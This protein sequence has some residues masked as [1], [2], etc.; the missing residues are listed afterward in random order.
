MKTLIAIIF[1][2]INFC[3]YTF[4]NLIQIN[5]VTIPLDLY[6]EIQ[7][8]NKKTGYSHD[9]GSYDETNSTYYELITKLKTRVK[10]DK[11]FLCPVC[12]VEYP[13]SKYSTNYFSIDDSKTLD[14][15]LCI[16]DLPYK[17]SYKLPT[18]CIFCGGIFS[19]PDYDP[20][21]SSCFW[22][23]WRC[24]YQALREEHDTWK[25]FAQTAYLHDLE[26]EYGIA[27]I[28]LKASRT[29]ENNNSKRQN[30]LN[31]AIEHLNKY[32]DICQRKNLEYYNDYLKNG[33]L[34]KKADFLRQ[35]GNFS[36]AASITVF[37]RNEID[38]KYS[39][40][41]IVLNFIDDLIA[42]KD[43]MPAILPFGNRLHWAIH[44]NQTIGSDTL[45][46]ITD[47]FKWQNNK[48]GLNPL[49]QAIV[50]QKTNYVKL[51]TEKQYNIFEN[52]DNY[53]AN[54]WRATIKRINNPQI[55]EYV[56]KA[57]SRYNLE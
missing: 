37:L 34:I 11:W 5:G 16:D 36:E 31:L 52:I 2:L 56:E 21:T 15:R 9:L 45:A 27:I 6:L 24:M 8:F 18:E 33:L 1:T 20:D 39:Y 35:S 57:L 42:Q 23:T 13:V 49:K 22:E 3:N 50:E 12:H 7:N 43:I 19:K 26:S 51:L 28:Y 55:T 47:E 48:Y 38:I 17:V 46:L 29:Y 32:I 41:G 4:D 25:M 44:N 30:Y 54:I 53:Q 14:T 40:Y 10:A